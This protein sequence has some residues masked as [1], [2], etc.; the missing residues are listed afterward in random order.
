MAAPEHVYSDR[1]AAPRTGLPIPPP[2]AWDIDRPGALGAVQPS[3]PGFGNPGPDQG[4]GLKLARMFEDRLVL[5][6]GE[7]HEDVVAGCLG[8]ALRRAS[9]FGRAPV[10]HDLTIA[11]TVWGYLDQAPEELVA[12][13]VPLFQACAHHYD[14]QRAIAEAV[15]EATLRATPAEVAARFP[16]EWKALLGR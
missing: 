11:F 9:L 10:V 13:R 16:G 4:Y 14:D 2:R 1:E 15:P 6:P 3:G 7:H 8:V 5:T 12:L